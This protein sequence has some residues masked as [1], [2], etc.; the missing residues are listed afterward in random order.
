M[1][2]TKLRYYYWE[3]FSF[4][5]E[6]RSIL[7]LQHEDLSLSSEEEV[8]YRGVMKATLVFKGGSCLL[9]RALLDDTAEIREYDYAYI[10]LG[11][12]G[13]RIFQYDDASHHPELSTHPHHRHR[14]PRPSRGADQAFALDIPQ[15]DFVTIVTKIEEEYLTD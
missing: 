15:V 10:Y 1:P 6:R 5:A 4:L 9:V 14:G 12:D 13:E 3:I 2:S 11:P 7:D 8:E